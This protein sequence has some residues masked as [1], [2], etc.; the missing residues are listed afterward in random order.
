MNYILNCDIK[1]QGPNGGTP[2][3]ASKIIS[4]T[5]QCCDILGLNYYP[6]EINIIVYPTYIHGYPDVWGLCYELD[7]GEINIH[8]ARK[9]P[10]EVSTDEPEWMKSDLYLTLAHELMHARQ[11]AKGEKMYERPVRKNEEFICEL[12]KERLLW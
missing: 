3:D 6:Y 10:V 7:D 4:F 9:V 5:E 1:V 11:T 2:R 8:L 12:V